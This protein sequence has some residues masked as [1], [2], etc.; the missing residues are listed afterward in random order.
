MGIFLRP[1][2]LFLCLL[3]ASLA[4]TGCN[5]ARLGSIAWNE[6]YGE[7][8]LAHVEK[9]VALGP[10]P[11][12]SEASRKTQQ[13]IAE[14]LK[15]AGLTVREQVF[16]VSTPTGA[17][18]MK[19]IIGEARGDSKVIL[20]L[21]AHYDT[22]LFDK[23]QFVGAN[24]GGAA[25]GVLLEAARILGKKPP[26]ATVWLVFFDGEEAMGSRFTAT[27]GSYGSRYFVSELGKDKTNK[28]VGA[29]MILDM[30][31]DKD[32]TVT[33]P[34]ESSQRLVR[35]VFDAAEGLQVREKFGYSTSTISDDH[36]PFLEAQIPAVDLID[37]EF[38]SKPGVN[39]YWHTPQD[40]MDKVSAASLQVAGRV[41]LRAADEICWR[42]ASGE[43]FRW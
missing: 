28:R 11:S 4:T 32:L 8:A 3:I 12:G 26:A 23:E 27:D 41:A 2:Y 5:K 43:R 33:I 13:Y 9:Q 31:G 15:A 37:F 7:K 24:D 34:P 38:G 18:Q 20:V 14:Q 40:T 6:F 29:A 42:L 10:R 39:D 21:G 22:K 35:A 17:V 30:I 1:F 36:T 16:S 25:T 19:N